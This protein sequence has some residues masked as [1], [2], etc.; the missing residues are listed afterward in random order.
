MHASDLARLVRA[1]TDD[2][3]VSAPGDVHRRMVGVVEREVL[4]HALAVTAGNQLRAA[5]LLGVNR[6]TLHKRAVQLGVLPAGPL[7][8]ERSG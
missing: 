6:N 7:P 5:R 2:L 3:I 1:I 4:A 8:V